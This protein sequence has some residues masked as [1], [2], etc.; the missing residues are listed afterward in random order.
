MSNFYINR[1][2]TFSVAEIP[3]RI[4]QMLVNKLEEKIYHGKP[5]LTL[6]PVPAKRILKSGI[7]NAAVH[8]D[9]V[10]IFGKWF[11]YENIQPADW[12]RD[13]FSGK[14]FPLSFAKKINI[15]KDPELSAKCVWEINRLQFL[16]QVAIKY[17][18]TKDAAVLNRFI[19]I[20]TSWNE[21]NPYLTGVN[22]YSNI[23][24]NLRLINW[25]LCWEVL[26]ADEL[27][28]ENSVF[29]SFVNDV[30]LPMIYQHC[31][32]SYKNPSKFS[33]ANNH[34]ISEYAGLF[35]ASV[36]W[37]FKESP[38][39]ISYSQKGLEEEII[40]QH[41]AN[42]VNK[43][44]AAEYIQFI[45]DFFLVAYVAGENSNHPFSK[46]YKEQLHQI[47]NYICSFLDSKGN[48]PKYGDED[49]GKCFIVDCDESFNNFKSLLTSGAVIFND[50]VL[51]AKSNGFDIKNQLLFGNAGKKIFDAVPDNNTEEGSKF[52]KEEGHFICRKKEN[53]QEVYFHFD[54]APLGFL[55]I[56]AHGHA[57]AL[58]FLMN[59]DGQP[60]FTDPGTYTYHTAP[61]W[62]NYFVS[63]LAH[64]TIRVNK[65]NQ[66]N[67]AGSTLWLNHYKCTVAN[68]ATSNATDIIKASHNGYEQ[69]GIT[70]TREIIFDKKLLQFTINDTVE[71]KNKESFFI[72]MPFHLHPAIQVKTVNEHVIQLI[73]KNGRNVQ[74]QTDAQLKTSVVCGQIEPEIAGWYSKSFLDKEPANT[75]ICSLQVQGRIQLQTIISIS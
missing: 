44:E 16:M 35:V 40:K 4:K 63:T 54:A 58:S 12:H 50:P 7:N 13:I 72:E 53:N 48:F 62:R 8:T 66:A 34:L 56:A 73:N 46:Q 17:Q 75:I 71:S 49:D 22:W 15:R 47:L 64:N 14:S 68:A 51:K 69:Y 52:Y 18:Q 3:Y 24:V 2:K 70:H 55:S 60:V 33:S 11:N 65:T 9:E 6:Q 74:L 42:G 1:L 30:W 31:V 38:Q 25:F 28:E 32:Y 36:K 57:D 23:E 29:E 67:F 26:N 21:S 27:I 45:T 10:H 5:V 20:N 37:P 41:S 61:E 43:E 19:S 59:V 39:W